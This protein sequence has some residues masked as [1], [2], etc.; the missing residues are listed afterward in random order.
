MKDAGLTSVD[1]W[2]GTGGLAVAQLIVPVIHPKVY[3]PNHWDGLFNSFWA[4]L[5]FPYKDA[6]LKAYLDQQNIALM[7]QSQYFDTSGSTPEARPC[8]RTTASNR[9]SAFLMFNPSPRR[10]ARQ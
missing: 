1:A 7:P 4:D 2:I 9:S 8:S 10:C 6:N 3:I 5:P